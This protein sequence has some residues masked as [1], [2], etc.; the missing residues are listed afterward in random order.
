MPPHTR[1]FLV[2]TLLLLYVCFYSVLITITLP[3]VVIGAF[4]IG[5]NDLSQIVLEAVLGPWV[6]GRL[7]RHD[8]LILEGVIAERRRLGE[9]RPMPGEYVPEEGIGAPQP[10]Q[11]AGRTYRILFMETQ[12]GMPNRIARYRGWL[13]QMEQAADWVAEDAQADDDAHLHFF[14]DWLA[15]F[16]QVDEDDLE[17]DD[18]HLHLFIDWV[19][20]DDPADDDA[21]LDFFIDWVAEDDLAD[22]DAH[23]DF[24]IE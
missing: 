16:V 2:F 7:R 3:M 14:L 24:F 10:Q 13:H 6:A 22:D 5:L 21:H 12:M 23:L 19:A 8:D 9:E 4:Q 11:G 18:A 17:D 15:E 1:I 20:E